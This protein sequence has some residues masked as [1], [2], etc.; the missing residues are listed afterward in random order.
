[1]WLRNNCVNATEIPSVNHTLCKTK[2]REAGEVKSKMGK[3]PLRGNNPPPP[4]PPPPFSPRLIRLGVVIAI[5]S[6]GV[7]YL[8]RRTSRRH[9]LPDRNVEPQEDGT[10]ET[11]SQLSVS[12]I[13]IY[14]LVN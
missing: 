12:Y 7:V 14:I 9:R 2:Q 3:C 8:W 4:P 13:Y 1:M 5:S 6:I 11:E 10:V